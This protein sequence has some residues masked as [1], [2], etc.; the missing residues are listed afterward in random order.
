MLHVFGFHRVGVAVGDLYFVDPSPGPGQEGAERGVRVE[1]RLLDSPERPGSIYAARP[2]VVDQPIWRADLLE[3]VAGPAG[4][5]DRTHHHPHMRGWEPGSRQ[6]DDEMSAEPLGFVGARLADL[7]G[8]L[9]GAGID[10]ASVDDR[11]A[12]ALRAEAPAIVDTVRRMLAAVRSGQLAQPSDD[13]DAAS[14]R[15]GW[16]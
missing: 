3:S 10:P 14:A 12:A 11:D 16:L 5:H 2:I 7:D 1:V 15:V 13:P 9:S 4:S 6:F 8:L